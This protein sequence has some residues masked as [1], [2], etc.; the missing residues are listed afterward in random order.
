MRGEQKVNGLAVLIYRAIEIAPL[1]FDLDVRLVQPPAHPYWTLAPMERLLELR[2][3]FDDS[4]VEGIQLNKLNTRRI[5]AKG[6][7]GT[8]A[9]PVESPAGFHETGRR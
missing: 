1:T 5:K 3:I 7:T 6:W 2:A 9:R 8:G 4:P